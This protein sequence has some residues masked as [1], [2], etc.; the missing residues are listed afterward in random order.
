[1]F[2]NILSFFPLSL[3]P[4]PLSPSPFPFS[5]FLF[6]KSVYTEGFQKSGREVW[7]WKAG[8]LL[9]EIPKTALPKESKERKIMFLPLSAFLFPF[10]FPFPANAFPLS[11]FSLFPETLLRSP[12][13]RNPFPSSLCPLSPLPL[14]P[15]TRF[16]FPPLLFLS[17]TSPFPFFPKS[18]Y[19]EGFQ[20][21]GREVWEWK[22]GILLP[23]I[24]KTALPN[25]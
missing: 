7:E 25:Q 21:S 15:C 13:P 4:F 5:H 20:K 19:T 16:P 22:A 18:V 14:H 3:S 23:E 2:L 11:V 24:P 9:P 10:F 12:F 8:I 6:P 1:M 17:S